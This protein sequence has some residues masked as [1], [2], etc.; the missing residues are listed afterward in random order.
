MLENL[1]YK[2]QNRDMSNAKNGVFYTNLGIFWFMKSAPDVPP[3]LDKVK[4]WLELEIKY[5]INIC[6]SNLRV[7]FCDLFNFLVQF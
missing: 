6:Q 7:F 4:F 5:Y 1:N 3:P 2:C